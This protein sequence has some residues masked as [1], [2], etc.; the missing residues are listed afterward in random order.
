M[1]EA[2]RNS[3]LETLYLAFL[4]K[5]PPLPHTEILQV[6]SCVHSDESFNPSTKK[7]EE[8]VNV[9]NKQYRPCSGIIH[10]RAH[11]LKPGTFR[12][13]VVMLIDSRGYS[14]KSTLMIIMI[15]QYCFMIIVRNYV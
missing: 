8:P 9:L 5:R 13:T 14:K 3:A 1:G 15:N 10:D 6:T 7:S 12:Q 11:R 4:L 2:S